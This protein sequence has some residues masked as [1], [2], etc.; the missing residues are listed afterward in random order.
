MH[1]HHYAWK[2]GAIHD[3]LLSS[4]D[5][6]SIALMRLR[7]DAVRVDDSALKSNL[8]PEWNFEDEVRQLLSMKHSAS[9]PQCPH[10]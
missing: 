4:R 10:N 7:S 5:V 8:N 9:T 1:S 6:E 3:F 2:D